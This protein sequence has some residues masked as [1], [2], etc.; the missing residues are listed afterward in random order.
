M[1]ELKNEDIVNNTENEIKK[2]IK[3]E[4]IFRKA[5]GFD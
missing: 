5:K 3:K 1:R 2:M 4:M